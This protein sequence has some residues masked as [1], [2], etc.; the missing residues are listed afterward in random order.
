MRSSPSSASLFIRLF[1]P[2]RSKLPL[3]YR[4]KR[5]LPDSDTYGTG[6]LS[7]VEEEVNQNAKNINRNEKNFVISGTIN[8]ERH[9]L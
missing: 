3:T 1:A 8:E 7:W 9:H 5:R 6:N 2:R 4:T